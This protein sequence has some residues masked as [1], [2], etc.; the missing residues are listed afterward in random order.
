MCSRNRS[1]RARYCRDK[2]GVRVAWID[3]RTAPVTAVFLRQCDDSCP[4]RFATTVGWL[5]SPPRARPD[6]IRSNTGPRAPGALLSR[7]SDWCNEDLSLYSD[8][9]SSFASV[10]VSI[11]DY[12][13]APRRIRWADNNADVR[14]CLFFFFG[15][16]VSLS[17]GGPEI[18]RTDERCDS[19]DRRN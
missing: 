14:L 8:A 10:Y 11:S 12:T 6:S 2:A 3:N 4:F 17:A 5:L 16:I 9:S 19:L 18:S 1:S 15:G 13:A 7:Y